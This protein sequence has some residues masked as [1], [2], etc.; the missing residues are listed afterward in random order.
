M[1]RPIPT[2]IDNRGKSFE[3]RTGVIPKGKR[4]AVVLGFDE[5]AEDF[6]AEV[7]GTPIGG[8]RKINIG[9]IEGI[10]YQPEKAV[11]EK[12]V[13]YSARFDE[14]LLTSPIQNVSVKSNKGT[15]TLSWVEIN[16]Y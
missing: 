2:E 10:G 4:C 16:V 11:S 3:L 14:S 12:T 9:F 5:G 8:F 1:W 13:C 6:T 15:P 7:N